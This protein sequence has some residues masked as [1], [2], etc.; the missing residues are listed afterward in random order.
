MKHKKENFK[1]GIPSDFVLD[2]P[3]RRNSEFSRPPKTEWIDVINKIRE[4]FWNF[5]VLHSKMEQVDGLHISRAFYVMT[6][7]YIDT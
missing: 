5:H 3:P 6:C 2:S 4:G 7:R 1:L